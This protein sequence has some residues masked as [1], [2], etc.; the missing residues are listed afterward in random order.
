MNLNDKL[1]SISKLPDGIAKI[2]T[3][4]Q[5]IRDNIEYVKKRASGEI[6][7]LGT[8]YNKLNKALGGGF[9]SNT[10]LTLSGLSGGG[11]VTIN[12]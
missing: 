2:I 9:E 3:Q 4:E 1:K 12:N 5:A 6:K 10:I 8:C 7:A 11:N